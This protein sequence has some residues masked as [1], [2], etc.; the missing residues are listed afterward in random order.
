MCRDVMCREVCVYAYVCM[1][2]PGN[3]CVWIWGDGCGCVWCVSLWGMCVAVEECVCVHM[4]ECRW[5]VL[6]ICMCVR[7]GVGM[8]VYVG[9]V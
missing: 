7:M 2:C 8:S 6:G 5:D 3:V 4:C 9:C 1:W